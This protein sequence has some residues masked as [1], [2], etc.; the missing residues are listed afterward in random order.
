MTST[1]LLD[2][3]RVIAD[4]VLYEGYLL[5]P[6][7]ASAAKNQVRW[8]FGVLG[9]IGAREA[10]CGED[11]AMST[12]CL[13][14]LGGE[15]TVDIRV[16]F[17]QLQ[18]RTV[19]RREATPR[20]LTPVHELTCGSQTW[21]SW[22]EAVEQEVDLAP[23]HIPELLDGVERLLPVE[24]PGG[25]EAELLRD[26]H[27]ELVGKVVRERLPLSAVLRVSARRVGGAVAVGL[28]LEN[29]HP[30]VPLESGRP[31]RDQALQRSLL[32]AHVVL[33]VLDGRFLSVI[34]PPAWASEAAAQCANHRCWPVLVGEKGDQDVV[35]AA[36]IILY[37]WPEVAAESPGDLFD[38]TEIDELLTLR[39]MT[40]TEDEK[41]EVR[42][43]DDRA[44][45]LLD[46]CESLPDTE[47]GRLHG[48]TR[49]V[50]AGGEVPTWSTPGHDG[51]DRPWWDPDV[52]A[53]VRPETDS[54]LVGGTPVAAGSHV[55]LRPSRRA[56]AQDLFLAGQVA[57][58]TRVDRDVDG[59]VHVAVVLRDDPA[60]DLHQW[61]GRY[62]YFGP[63]EIE[64]LE[65]GGVA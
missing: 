9:P 6:Y 11:S 20:R 25:A 34:D 61:Y 13:L 32:S 4:A 15:T 45:A 35:L 36:P 22:D 52:D 58:V 46:R 5:Y 27:G 8:Q 43:T 28:R 57:V 55:R 31:H 26:E 50:P 62:L 54:V 42:A 16:R 17:L 65:P 12:D 48:T 29:Q 41:R 21:L 3:A 33:S 19:W 30:W 7:R 40:L 37:D 64:P 51:A 14:E 56:D 2:R 63:E 18:S 49:E 60:G 47:L 24:V 38:S 23:Q 1:D 10:G 44:R 39:V 59:R 53:S